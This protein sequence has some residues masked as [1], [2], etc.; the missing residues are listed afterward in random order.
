M[1]VK[2]TVLCENSVFSNPGAISEHGWSVFLETTQ[3]NYL[4]DTGQG[5]ALL[6]NA[7]IFKKDLTN[8]KGIILSHHHWDH[9]GGLLNAL[10]V[11]EKVDVY[12]HPD[13]FK[14]SYIIKPKEKFVG[15]PFNRTVLESKGAKFIF[16][17]SFT[18][19]APSIFL[20]GEIPRR[21]QYEIGDTDLVLKTEKG[22]VKDEIF[23]DQTMVI[24]TPKGLFVI[25]GCSHSGII[26][27]LEYIVEKT[28]KEHF[29]T[30]IGG[31][32]LGP[33]GKEQQIK[34]IDALKKFSIE[35]IGVSHCT[36]LEM[37]AALFYEFKERFFFCNV[38]T[39]AKL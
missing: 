9:T 24:D 22:Y 33:I 10:S 29:H 12:C 6:N 36:G 37:S 17:N 26:N 18:E 35:K 3:G 19:I 15:I 34:T 8:I 1:E 13:I 5:I 2:A 27:I 16:N 30:I 4:F 38:G 39:V 21:T 14:E 11:I 7:R 25:L 32:H 23:D 31:T 28:G 20:T